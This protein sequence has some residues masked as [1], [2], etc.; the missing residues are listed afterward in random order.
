ML[1]HTRLYKVHIYTG[2]VV[3]AM[4][5]AET[6]QV[7]FC[8]EERDEH[9]DLST[10]FASTASTPRD[11]AL[12]ARSGAAFPS[13]GQGFRPDISF[14]DPGSSGPHVAILM[15][16]FNGAAFLPEQL[17]SLAAQTHGNWRLWAADD[18]SADATTDILRQY[19][20]AWGSDRLRILTGPRRGVQYNFLELAARE[21][22][23]A[24]YYAWSDQDDIWLPGKLARA[25]DRLIPLG[26]KQPAVYC[27]R[28]ILTSGR[29]E[30]YAL[31]PL[32]NRRFPS[33]ANALLQN[34]CGGNTAVFN[35]PARELIATG[36]KLEPVMHDWWAYLIVS[37]SGGRIIYDP[38]PMIR[39]RQHGRNL[40]SSNR[41]PRARW[42]R[43][44]KLFTGYL[45]RDV[46]HNLK[47]LYAVKSTLTMENLRYLETLTELRRLLNPARRLRRFMDKGFY[48]Q[49]AAEQL[50]AY[51]AVLLNRV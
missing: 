21:D 46:E 23:A 26:Q 19:Q 17:D 10:V 18:G 7:S 36:A 11:N 3:L 14:S 13:S 29:G 44:K 37:G 9:P 39:Y 20:R 15:G 22:L 48:R 33:F 12:P 41:G 16:T 51:A 5:D 50:A 28:A 35:R 27:G 2:N 38:E 1:Q 40:I 31:S 32:H 25:L 47:S 4:D 34:I 30:D 8:R 45:K 49:S 24:D 6:G 43:F 42:T